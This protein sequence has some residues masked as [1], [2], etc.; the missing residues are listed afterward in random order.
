MISPSHQQFSYDQQHAYHHQQGIHHPQGYPHQRPVVLQQQPQHSNLVAIAGQMEPA[1]HHRPPS[2]P[3]P[4]AGAKQSHFSD[5]FIDDPDPSNSTTYV[6]KCVFC[7]NLSKTK[8][9]FWRHLSERHYKAELSKELPA[10][11][12][13]KCPYQGCAYETKDNTISPLIKHYGIVHK[14]VQKYLSGKVGKYVPSELKP[15]SAKSQKKAEKAEQNAMSSSSEV[16]PSHSQHHFPHQRP[17]PYHLQQQ[18]GHNG[19]VPHPHPPDL[20]P[21]QHQQE[22]H[23][24]P[25]QEQQPPPPPPPQ[26]QQ[27]PPQQQQ[28]MTMSNQSLKVKCPFCDLMFA[29]RYSFYQHLCDKHFKDNLSARLPTSA[30]L[31]CPAEGCQYVAKDSRQSLIRHFGMTHKVVVDLLK[32]YVEGYDENDSVIEGQQ[33]QQLPPP[34]TPPQQQP[35]LPQALPAAAEQQQ[36]HGYPPQQLPQQHPD[37]HHSGHPLVPSQQHHQQ[38]HPPHGHGPLDQRSLPPIDEYFPAPP[39]AGAA[40]YPGHLPPPNHTGQYPPHPQQQQQ[41]HPQQ[42]TEMRFEQQIDGTF[43]PSH[44]SDHS[45]DGSKSMSSTPVKDGSVSSNSPTNLPPITTAT[46][47]TATA[48]TPLVVPPQVVLPIAPPPP[49]VPSTSNSQEQLEPTP[50]PPPPSESPKPTTT[51]R[52]P[53]SPPKVC[54]I[55][56]KT[57]EGKNRAMLKVQHMAQHFREKLFADLPSKAPPYKCPIEGCPYETKHKPDWARHYGSVHKYLDKYLKEYLETHEPHPKFINPP[58]PTGHIKAADAKKSVKKKACAPPIKDEDQNSCSST[59]AKYTT[60]L[61]KDHLTQILN[62]RARWAW[63][64]ASSPLAD[65]TKKS[66]SI[67]RWPTAAA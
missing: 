64:L 55:C 22:P 13:Y 33:Q 31:A 26:A 54:E 14:Q 57:F 5:Q 17:H 18:E 43:D 3:S 11:P 4:G 27:Q 25:P 39:G 8:S 67:L 10:V 23:P 41:M 45:L 9:D 24:P 2:S 61:P 36:L 30:P 49:P 40:V 34:P 47:T 44:Y 65:R 58:A 1:A 29:A 28:P 7:S 52:R 56:G 66:D 32:Q 62:S 38:L 53:L 20:N 12:P 51:G 21:Y 46:T 6:I 59:D 15:P 19:M 16:S 37:Y 63:T 50:T 48:V 42:Q 35:H 60:Y